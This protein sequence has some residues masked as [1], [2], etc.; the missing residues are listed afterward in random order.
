MKWISFSTDKPKYSQPVFLY[1]DN[2]DSENYFSVVWDKSEEKY[3]KLNNISHW[4]PALSPKEEE[5]LLVTW[6]TMMDN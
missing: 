2:G 1:Q 6:D 5:E 4:K 3:Q